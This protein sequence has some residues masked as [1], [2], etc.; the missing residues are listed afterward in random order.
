MSTYSVAGASGFLVLEDKC[1]KKI[2]CTIL[3]K[4]SLY[5]SRQAENVIKEG[6]KEYLY[7]SDLYNIIIVQNRRGTHILSR[8]CLA[9]FLSVFPCINMPKDHYF[10]DKYFSPVYCSA[11]DFY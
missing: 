5:I 10:F 2:I 8:L 4:I 11:K 9:F 7:F 1:E 3:K 6:P